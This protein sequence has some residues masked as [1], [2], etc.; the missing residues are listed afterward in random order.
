MSTLEVCDAPSTSGAFEDSIADLGIYT[1]HLDMDYK[2]SLN[3]KI[4]VSSARR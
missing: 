1:A 3:A 4:W 2:A